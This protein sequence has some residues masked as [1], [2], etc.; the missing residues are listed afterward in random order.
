MLAPRR[1]VGAAGILHHRVTADC[2][3][4]W[5][6]TQVSLRTC[7]PPGLLDATAWTC[8]PNDVTAAGMSVP[9][10]R[11]HATCGRQQAW[12]DGQGAE[13][14]PGA[15]QV[16]RISGDSMV[17][18]ASGSTRDVCSIAAGTA[19]ICCRS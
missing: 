2:A 11:G 14:D 16:Q 8:P 5:G 1:V 12:R 17:Q 4:P 9:S 7:I 10:M 3:G 6:R 15:S 18:D 13:A 19:N